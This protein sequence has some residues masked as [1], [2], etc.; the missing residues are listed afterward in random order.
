M[1][2][3]IVAVGSMGDLVPYTGLATRLREAGHAVAVATYERFAAVVRRTGAEVRV[4]PGDPAAEGEWTQ[5]P[6]SA[7]AM[8][9]ITSGTVA[10]GEHIYAVAEPSDDLILLCQSAIC[11][12]H[13]ADRLG[14]PSAGVFFEPM[15]P[16]AAHPPS[17]LGTGRSLGAVGNRLT[18]R[19][20]LALGGR[21]M[22]GPVRVLRRRLGLP[23]QSGRALA[24][25][26]ADWPILHAY[27]PSVLPRPSDWPS[28]LDV[29]GYLWPSITSPGWT[30]PADL[31][32]FLDAGEPPVFVGFGSRAMSDTESRR[33]V[34][35]VEEALSR[36]G[37]RGVIQAGWARLAGRSAHTFTIRETLTPHDWLFPRMAAVVH[38]MGAGTAAAGLRAGVPSVGV[39]I[40]GAQPFWAARIAGLGAGPAP[41]PYRKLSTTRLADAITAAVS[42]R[43]YRDTAAALSERIAGEDGAGAIVTVLDRLVDG[44]PTGIPPSFPPGAAAK[45]P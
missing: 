4:I 32:D 41:V 28:A 38:H 11:G 30:P 5:A 40:L 43:S 36:A 13:A 37:V 29:T 16:T 20:V 22:R 18:G 17:Y 3:L 9:R 35:I 42:Y 10:L 6:N 39:P 2:V 33:V 34:G 44:D 27:S 14:I 25:R 45:E 31:A 19:L 21:L 8:R 12:V 24:A 1:N 23:A 26:M 15:H 7:G